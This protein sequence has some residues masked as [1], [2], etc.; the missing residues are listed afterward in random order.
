MLEQMNTMTMNVLWVWYENWMLFWVLVGYWSVELQ[1]IDVNQS[2]YVLVSLAINS[3]KE[4]RCEF[5]ESYFKV[6]NV[7]SVYN[8]KQIFLS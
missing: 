7:S 3:R 2:K 6:H 5:T 8:V 1:S 4:L